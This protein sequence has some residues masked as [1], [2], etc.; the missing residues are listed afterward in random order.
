MIALQVRMH[1]I[2]YSKKLSK[3]ADAQHQPFYFNTK[4]MFKKLYLL[5][6]LF[7]SVIVAQQQ[8]ITYSI[9][10]ATFE[11]DETV[12]ITINGNSINEATWGIANNALY[13]WSWSFDLNFT[14]QQDCPTNGTWNNSS[15]TNK[16]T[17]NSGND[18]YSISFISNEFYN[19]TNIGR[20]GFLVKAK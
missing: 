13:L 6:F 19:R 15:E 17:Y 7:T 20:I 1:S 5:L 16:L 9:S 10:P 3:K 2:K 11:E 14:N 8:N 18:T 12:T 4:S